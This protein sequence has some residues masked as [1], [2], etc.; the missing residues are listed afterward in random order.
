MIRAIL[1]DCFGVLTESRWTARV[2]QLAPDVQR[3]VTD[4]HHAYERGFVEYAEYRREVM[5]LAGL[6]Q[7]EVDELFIT[8]RGYHKNEEL[9]S[10]IAELAGSYKIA[11]LSNAGSSWVRDMLLSPDEG[12]LFS[13]M[14]LSFEV[15]LIKPDPAIY[16][17]ACQ[18]LGIEPAEA[19]FVDDQLGYCQAAEALGMQAVVYKNIVQF[20]HE[21]QELLSATDQ[22]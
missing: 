16:H 18:R 9:L 20:K 21:L 10:Y 13:D 8:R 2:S 14:V 19:V 5:R 4:I 7:E 12:K 17:L 1:F 22:S 6:T 3:E 15:G 11:I